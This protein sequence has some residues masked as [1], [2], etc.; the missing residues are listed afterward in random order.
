MYVDLGVLVWSG[1]MFY[2]LCWTGAVD[3]VADRVWNLESRHIYRNVRWLESL[4][5]LIAQLS[6]D[7]ELIACRT[8]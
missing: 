3:D 1:N 7:G 2:E 4:W 5:W 6:L 8:G